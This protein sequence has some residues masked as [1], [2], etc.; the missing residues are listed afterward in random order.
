MLE[1]VGGRGGAIMVT[2]DGEV[3]RHYTTKRMAWA[4]LNKRGELDSG[5]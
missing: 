4:S 3:G 1:R 5:L 2:R